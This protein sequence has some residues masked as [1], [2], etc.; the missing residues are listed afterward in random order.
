MLHYEHV[1]GNVFEKRGKVNVVEYW[2]NTIVKISTWSSI[3]YRYWQWIHWMPKTKEKAPINLHFTCQLT[4]I[5]ETLKSNISEA[6]KVQVDC[7]KESESDSYDKN[8][9]KERVNDLVRLHEAMQEQLKTESYLEQ[10]Q[11]PT[12]VPDKWSRMYCSEYLNVFEYLVWTSHEIKKVGGILAK[13]APKKK[14][15]YHH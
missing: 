4:C 9:M 7:F 5:Y 3:C 14:K 11:I 13:P 8:D 10:I 15:S 12:L 6:Y 2:W 1:F